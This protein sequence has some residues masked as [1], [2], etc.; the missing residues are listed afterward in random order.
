MF[1]G[2]AQQE[3]RCNNALWLLNRPEEALDRD[4]A[5]AT[6]QLWPCHMGG[7]VHGQTHHT[8]HSSNPSPV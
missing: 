5:H 6:K 7:C 2:V 8:A 4:R 3:E 1:N